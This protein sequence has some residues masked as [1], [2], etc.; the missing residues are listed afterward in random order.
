MFFYK[1]LIEQ[2]GDCVV[3]QREFS[4]LGSV[5]HAYFNAIPYLPGDF[6]VGIYESAQTCHKST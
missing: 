3:L 2:Y 6:H 1:S 4:R 5:L